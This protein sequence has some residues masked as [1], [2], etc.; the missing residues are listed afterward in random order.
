MLSNFV[1]Y[2]C[3]LLI[4]VDTFFKSHFYFNTQ[5]ITF[6]FNYWELFPFIKFQFYLHITITIYYDM[7][8]NQ[9]TNANFVL[10]YR[11][12]KKSSHKFSQK[13]INTKY[14]IVTC[15]LHTHSRIMLGHRFKTKLTIPIQVI[16][17]I[18]C[19]NPL[20]KLRRRLQKR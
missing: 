18:P 14:F 10:E 20:A 5:F 2:Y 8:M 6:I 16:I 15:T 1:Q 9:T 17:T 4:T 12:K 7:V 11:K 3:H 13:D 19:L